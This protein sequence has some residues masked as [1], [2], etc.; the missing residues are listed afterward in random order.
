MQDL[1]FGL[2]RGIEF[3]IVRVRVLQAFGVWSL[4]SLGFEGSGGS[5]DSG[6]E[7]G[8]V[9][10]VGH[11]DVGLLEATGCGV[12]RQQ[13]VG[14]GRLDGWEAFMGASIRRVGTREEGSREEGWQAG[15]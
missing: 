9:F 12:T 5:V 15:T 3:R 11:R 13:G 2:Q 1:G 6:I 8:F 4:M 14:L 7:T 10:E